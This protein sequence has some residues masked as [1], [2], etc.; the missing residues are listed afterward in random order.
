VIY[1]EH[2]PRLDDLTT[3]A[4]PIENGMAAAPMTPGI[5]VE[6]DLDAVKAKSLPEFSLAFGR[7]AQS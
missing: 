4:L 2:I 7:G 1:V 5:D 3:S 6:W